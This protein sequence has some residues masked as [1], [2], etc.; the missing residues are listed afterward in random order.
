MVIQIQHIP[1]PPAH[2][3]PGIPPRPKHSLS[4]KQFPISPDGAEHPPG[5]HWTTVNNDR[6]ETNLI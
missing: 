5:G 6:T 3:P 4:A 1:Y 2:G